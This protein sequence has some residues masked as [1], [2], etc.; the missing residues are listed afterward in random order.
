[1]KMHALDLNDAPSGTTD[2]SD[3]P[4]SELPEK[5]KT[6]LPIVEPFLIEADLPETVADAL[7]RLLLPDEAV[8]VV[9][10]LNSSHHFSDEPGKDEKAPMWM[11]LTG[12]RL[13]VVAVASDGR[14]YSDVF[15]QRNVIEYHNGLSG[16]SLKVEETSLFSAIWERKR[17]LL[18]EAARLFPLPEYEKYLSLAENAL[19]KGKR[20]HAVA[21][22]QKSLEHTPTLK[23]YTMLLSILLRH[24]HREEA[25]ALVEDALRRVD[26]ISLFEEMLRL[27]PE[28]AEMPFY[29][30]AA[31]ERHQQWDACI[32]IYQR[33]LNNTPDF[34]LYYLK[35]GDMLNV[36]HEYEAAIAQYQKFIEL[37]A[38]SDK[39]E[40]GAFHV[41]NLED[42]NVFSADPDLAK[43]YFEV[44][45]IYEYDVKRLD[46]AAAAYLALLRHAPFY[47]DAYKH[48]WQVYQQL[49]EQMPAAA[50]REFHVPMFLQIFRLL[51]PQQYAA[52]VTQEQ[53]ALVEQHYT[54]FAGLPGRYHRLKEEN[55]ERLMHPG[56][57]EYFRRVQHWLTTLVVSKDD[58]EGIEAYCE[59]VGSANYPLLHELIERLA[60]FLDIIPPKC[61]IS[62][63][64]IGISVRNTEH[65]F[66]FIGSEHLQPDN[67]RFFSQDE[68]VFMVASQIEHIKSG[69]LLITDTELWKNLGS[70]SF[71]GFLLAL[72]CLPAG[73]FLSRL[74]HHVATTGL[75]KVYNMTRTSGMQR[76]FDFFKK[77]ADVEEETPEDEQE[78]L[79]EAEGNGKQATKPES[80]FKEQVVEFARH[81]IYTADRIG[82]LACNR[83]DAACSGIFKIAGQGFSE[84]DDLQ[85]LGLS[86]ILSRRDKRGNFLYF[87]YAK[88]FSELIQ[89]AL[90]DIYL[91]VHSSVVIPSKPAP[92][93]NIEPAIVPT[94]PDYATLLKERLQLLYDSFCNELLTPEEFLNKQQALLTQAGSF[95]DEHARVIQKLQQAFV[96]GILTSEELQ[97]KVF[98]LLEK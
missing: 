6:T 8:F 19:K 27:F 46:L 42:F 54:F 71:D 78:K 98:R 81:A 43:A 68:L 2:S 37:R 63:G 80:L 59:Q 34:D 17:W 77:P 51:A 13:L 32:H 84:L 24:E 86:D 65:P 9:L 69:H 12:T 20:L 36:K 18:K 45:L 52:T 22:L 72:Q 66:I 30:A 85:T 91:L 31:C 79:E 89:F 3:I 88:R 93:Q 1:M 40:K 94:P 95:S 35:L 57:Q 15:D 53:I 41:W 87:E 14:V 75:K 48:F 74:T 21:L 7:L 82:L 26:P 76:W 49:L 10:R 61:F 55:E 16:D 4:V 64:K 70:A 58:S 50:P 28:N 97:Q 38:A 60:N 29:L 11:A 92:I 83:F 96:D 39:F 23:A 73:G 44:G 56:E 62:R 5:P 47:V 25:E 33:L 90:S 67:E